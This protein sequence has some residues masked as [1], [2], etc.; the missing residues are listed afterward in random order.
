MCERKG[1]HE[2]LKQKKSY[3]HKDNEI[4]SMTCEGERE[5]GREGMREREGERVSEGVREGRAGR[6]G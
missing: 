3:E 2:V 6:E 4:G 5:R 1:P